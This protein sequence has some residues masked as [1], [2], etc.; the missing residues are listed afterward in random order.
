MGFLVPWVLM[1]KDDRVVTAVEN[2]QFPQK[3]EACFWSEVGLRIDHRPATFIGV[4]V[5]RQGREELKD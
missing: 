1:Y 2:K 3:Q 4:S 5:Q